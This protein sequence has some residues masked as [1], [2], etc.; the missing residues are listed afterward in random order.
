MPAERGRRQEG[1]RARQYQPK[2][3]EA[4]HKR[5]GRATL[6]GE[7]LALGVERSKGSASTQKEC[8]DGA[9]E[10]QANL[11]S[12]CGEQGVREGCGG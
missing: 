5:A 3:P 10:L 4:L 7:H 6:T 12:V 2:D 11:S 9:R 8:Q 1:H